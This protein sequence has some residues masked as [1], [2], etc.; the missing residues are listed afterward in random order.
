MNTSDVFNKG[1]LDSSTANL[2]PSKLDKSI[3][4]KNDTPT[5]GTP[6]KRKVSDEFDGHLVQRDKCFQLNLNSSVSLR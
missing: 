2:T 4:P 6:T 5:K 1:F 3:L